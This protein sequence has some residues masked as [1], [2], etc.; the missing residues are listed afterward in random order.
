[1]VDTLSHDDETDLRWY[2][3]EARGDCGL[4]SVMGGQ[5]A[6]LHAN[7]LVSLGGSDVGYSKMYVRKESGGRRNTVEDAMARICDSGKPARASAVAGRLRAIAPCHAATLEAQYS[8]AMEI[9]GTMVSPL[10]A[11]QQPLARET[12][13]E[14]S[15]RRRKRGK[16]S[17]DTPLLWLS[18]LIAATAE[19]PTGDEARILG[20]IISQARTALFAACRA[21]NGV[22]G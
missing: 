13:R 19:R 14:L 6:A 5:I 11:T 4:R 1:M 12:F 16:A 9:P 21:Y 2:L 20:T 8:M 10:L 17:T 7:A 18:S 15:I 22:R 3:T